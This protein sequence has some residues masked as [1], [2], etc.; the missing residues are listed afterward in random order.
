[1]QPF[2]RFRF[3]HNNKELNYD[4]KTEI[5][6]DIG[7]KIDKNGKIQTKSMIP[8]YKYVK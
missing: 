3:V 5:L 1:M 7:F 4:K 2:K 8:I 6:K